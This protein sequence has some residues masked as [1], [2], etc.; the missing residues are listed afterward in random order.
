M[1]EKLGVIPEFWVVS[2]PGD[3]T[4]E[5][6]YQKLFNL[7]KKQGTGYVFK[8]PI[9]DFKVGLQGRVILTILLN[10][11]LIIITYQIGT[12]DLLVGLSEELAKL[13][14]FTERFISKCFLVINEYFFVNCE[15]F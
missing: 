11:L 10:F 12:L 7:I 3:K 5:E 4:G 6:T 1:D 9:P 13:D 8:F 14:S 15:S 2:A